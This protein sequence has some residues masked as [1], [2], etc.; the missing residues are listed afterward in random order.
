MNIKL[1]A[2]LIAVAILFGLFATVYTIITFPIVLF[3]IL[4]GGVVYGLYKLVFNH[5]VYQ[6]RIGNKR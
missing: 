6:Q 2:F 3:F 5:L 4:I 1:K